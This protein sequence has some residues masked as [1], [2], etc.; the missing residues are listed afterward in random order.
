M[1]AGKGKS[2]LAGI[3]RQHLA[4]G[5]K[6]QPTG[7]SGLYGEAVKLARGLSLRAVQRLGELM[8]SEDERVSVVACN[9]LL[10][11][12]FGKPKPAVEEKDDVMEARLKTMSREER[13]ALLQEL[14]EPMRKYLPPGEDAEQTVV[15]GEAVR[16]RTAGAAR[17]AGP[18]HSR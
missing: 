11:R 6:R 14:L 18:R 3:P 13:L 4:A 5:A 17:L 16:D 12:A 2:T 7:H 15:G 1:S 8:E 10:D 9:S